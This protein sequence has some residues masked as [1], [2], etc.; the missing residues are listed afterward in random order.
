MTSAVPRKPQPK[1]VDTKSGDL[2]DV[3]KS[4]LV[5]KYMLEGTFGKVPEYIQRRK[6]VAQQRAKARFQAVDE[7]YQQQRF[8]SDKERNEILTV[9]FIA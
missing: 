2:F 5:P 9:L 3:N 6:S 4:G 7:Q 8:I 1:C